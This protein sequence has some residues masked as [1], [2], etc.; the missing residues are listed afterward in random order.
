M[1]TPSRSLLPSGFQRLVVA[2]AERDEVVQVEREI[3]VG[4]DL[5]QVVD[6]EPAGAVAVSVNASAVACPCLVTNAPPPRSV[7]HFLVELG[8]LA[9]A[10]ASSFGCEVTFA[11]GPADRFDLRYKP[12]A[13]RADN[14]DRTHSIRPPPL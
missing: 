4:F 6:L 8:S 11:M 7:H 1:T 2:L 9:S 10:V 12:T 14:R 3:A 5:D 13:F